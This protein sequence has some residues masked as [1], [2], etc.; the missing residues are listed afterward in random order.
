MRIALIGY[1]KMGKAIESLSAPVHH[2]ISLKVGR[3]GFTAKDLQQTD[4]AIEF[5]T[6]DAAVNNIYTCFEAGIPVVVGTTAW[7]HQY[8]EVVAACKKANGKMLTATNFSIGVNLFWKAAEY[9]AGLMNERT[10]YD[11][12]VHEVHHL[13]KLDAPSGTAIT[14]A[15]KLIEQLNRKNRW[16]HHEIGNSPSDDPFHLN[17]SSAREEGVP[18]THIIEFANDIDSIELKHTAKNRKG[19][20]TGALKAAEWLYQQSEPG[21]Y[22]MDDVLNL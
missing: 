7:Y 19:F 6:P 3:S 13:Q 16:V 10:D 17:I 5:S 15:N 1:G 2:E 18:G 22:T 8:D 4:V 20:A 14:T 9:L 21:V 11:V 12:S